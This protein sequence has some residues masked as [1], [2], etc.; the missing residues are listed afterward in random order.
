MSIGPGTAASFM[1]LGAGTS[2]PRIF[3]GLKEFS[4]FLKAS[5]ASEP[6][7]ILG[8]AS[9]C[10]AIL[11][12]SI[13]H[14]FGNDQ[15]LAPNTET[16]QDLR[17]DE[18]AGGPLYI[19]GALLQKSIE[20]RAVME[21]DGALAGCG[22]NSQ[23]LVWQEHGFTTAPDSM[24]PNKIVPPRPV[25]ALGVYEAMPTLQKVVMRLAIV[26][27]EWRNM[28]GYL[29]S[30]SNPEALMSGAGDIKDIARGQMPYQSV[31]S[32]TAADVT[33]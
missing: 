23:I 1:D 16:T 8:T 29:A 20:A 4:A 22:S 30:F 19:D 14:N 25:F 17:S 24:I 13:Q 28:Q 32:L 12:W 5:A 9:V 21:G 6:V 10:A 18:G 27:L 15:K 3:G 2:R 33:F 26:G 11:K 31:S 7:K